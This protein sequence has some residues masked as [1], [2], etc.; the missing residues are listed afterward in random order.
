[1]WEL[2]VKRREVDASSN[3]F[4][5]EIERE[6]LTRLEDRLSLGDQTVEVV[7]HP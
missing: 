4:S 6:W 7:K 5:E 3:E 1:M 2:V